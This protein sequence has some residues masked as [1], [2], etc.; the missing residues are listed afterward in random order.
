MG[1]IIGIDTS[2]Y[3]TSMAVINKEEELLKEHRLVLKVPE[4]KR[5]LQQSQAVFQ[6]VQN[7]KTLFQGINPIIKS[8][9]ILAIVASTRPRSVEDSYMPVFTVGE[10]QGRVLS[11]FL[12]VPFWAT[13]H[14]EGHLLAGLWSS[15][16][17][18]NE[19]FLAVHLSGGTSELLRV[20]TGKGKKIFNIDCLGGTLDLHAGQFVD[21]VGVAMGL[22]FPA[23]THLEKLAATSRGQNTYIPTYV[24][25]YS[26]SFSG[27]ETSALRLVTEGYPFEVVA[28][29][30]ENCI[31]KTTEKVVSK[32][33]RSTGLKNILLVGGVAA[34]RHLRTRLRLRLEHNAVGGKLFFA[35]P[36]FSTDNAVGTAISGLIALQRGVLK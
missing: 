35:D 9:N 24:N 32:A 6:H 27:G 28:R 19:D 8:K 30:V 17:D 33:I 2:C 29:A 10:S 34:N 5:G 26:F 7:M 1:I 20:T 31:A 13:S 3:T 12:G 15:K 23:G 11:E 22:P 16:L 25:G 4:G 21:R 18:W 36:Y 14:Q